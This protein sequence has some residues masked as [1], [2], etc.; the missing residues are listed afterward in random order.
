VFL[1]G[2]SEKSNALD[3][4]G[5]TIR[6]IGQPH[7]HLGIDETTESDGEGI[8]LPVHLD[9]AADGIE[10]A[11]GVSQ[12]RYHP[13]RNVGEGRR[14]ESAILCV[15]EHHQC[16]LAH[17]EMRDATEDGGVTVGQLVTLGRQLLSHVGSM[18]NGA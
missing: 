11:H 6:F 2:E 3:N 5:G 9:L 16:G 4:L 18:L 17:E 12:L 7:E 15:F 13:R 14:C 1:G 10:T 8:E